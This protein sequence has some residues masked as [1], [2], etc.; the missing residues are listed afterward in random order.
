MKKLKRFSKIFINENKESDMFKSYSVQKNAEPQKPYANVRLVIDPPEG[1]KA[2]NLK[3]KE[4]TLFVEVTH[5]NKNGELNK[6]WIPLHLA[7]D[8]KILPDEKTHYGRKNETSDETDNTAL[9]DR[10]AITDFIFPRA[11]ADK[12]KTTPVILA[13]P[14]KTLG[15]DLMLSIP[16]GTQKCQLTITPNGNVTINH[17]PSDLT[18]NIET[19][20]D[21]KTGANLQC[22][23]LDLNAKNIINTHS[24]TTSK[25]KLSAAKKIIN[26]GKL[27]GKKSLKA[28]GQNLDNTETGQMLGNEIDIIGNT[29]LK[30]HGLVEAE[31]KLAIHTNT[32]LTNN[33]TGVLK[34][35]KIL[36]IHVK[37]LI[38]AGLSTA[39]QSLELLCETIILNSGKMDSAGSL[40]CKANKIIQDLKSSRI[41]SEQRLSLEAVTEILNAGL[42]SGNETD[43]KVTD[44]LHGIIKQLSDA[45]ISAE[46][47]LNLD[48]RT[49]QNEGL[50]QSVMGT[51]Q[52]KASEAFKNDQTGIVKA[53]KLLETT[54]NK[55]INSGLMECA[56]ILKCNANTFLQ[57]HKNSKMISGRKFRLSVKDTLKNHGLLFGKNRF[58]ITPTC[59]NNTK[60]GVLA[61]DEHLSLSLGAG[62]KNHGNLFGKNIHCVAE[63]FENNVTGFIK[64]NERLDLNI[65]RFRNLGRIESIKE[66][67]IKTKTLFENFAS[68]NILSHSDMMLFCEAIIQNSGVIESLG[69]IT[70]EAERILQDLKSSRLVSEQKL[71]LIATSLI[72]NLGAMLGGSIEATISSYHQ[73]DYTFLQMGEV[74]TKSG[75]FIFKGQG[76][77]H[78]E[79]S[80]KTNHHIDIT[81]I[82]INLLAEMKAAK[83]IDLHYGGGVWVVTDAVQAAG[84]LGFY[85]PEGGLITEERTVPGSLRYKLSPSATQP[86]TFLANQKAEN[87][88]LKIK[89]P[90]PVSIGNDNLFV[91][92]S[93]TEK[94][95]TKGSHFTLSHGRLLGGELQVSSDS[96]LLLGRAQYYCG[97]ISAGKMTLNATNNMVWDHL[98]VTC[99]G[100]FSAKSALFDDISSRTFIGENAFLDIPLSRHYLRTEHKP[101][102]YKI[103]WRDWDGAFDSYKVIGPSEQALTGPATLTVTKK[104]TLTGQT[105]LYGSQMSCSEFA[106]NGPVPTHFFPFISHRNAYLCGHKKHRKAHWGYTPSENGWVRAYGTPTLANFSVGNTLQTTQAIVNVQGNVTATA[107]LIDGIQS[108]M[109]GHRFDSILRLPP[110]KPFRSYIPL[111]E[112]LKPTRLFEIRDNGFACI[113]Q[114]VIPL[115]LSGPL[116]PIVVVGADGVLRPNIDNTPCLL[117]PLQ[118]ANLVVDALHE[119]IQRG[120][121]APGLTEPQQVLAVLRENAERCIQTHQKTLVCKDGT[122]PFPMIVYQEIDFTFASGNTKKVLVPDFCIP[123][124]LDNPRL[125]DG[126]AGLFTIGGDMILKGASQTNADLKVSGHLD[127][128]GKIVF[129]QFK[130]VTQAARTLTET[131][132]LRETHQTKSCGGLIEK[133][134]QSERIVQITKREPGNTLSATAVEYRDITDVEW[135]GAQMAIGAGGIQ[136]HNVDAIREK[137]LLTQTI[138]RIQDTQRNLLGAT[139]IT[140]DVV[141]TQIHP[142]IIASTGPVRL[143]SQH[144]YYDTLQVFSPTP[145]QITAVKSFTLHKFLHD[146]DSAQNQL[147]AEIAENQRTAK[148]KQKQMVV[149]VVVST[150]IGYGAMSCITSTS[151]FINLGLKGMHLVVAK[152]AIVGGISAGLMGR[153]PVLGALEGGAFAGVAHGVGNLF[154][155]SF[156]FINNDVFREAILQ[157]IPGVAVGGLQTV[158]HG[159]NVVENMVVGGVANLV[160]NMVVPA[161]EEGVALS[162]WAQ[163]GQAILRVAMTSG[164]TLILTGSES[165]ALNM[166]A[167]IA[168]TVAQGL[169][170]EFGVRMANV[171]NTPT[172]LNA[173]RNISNRSALV[174]RNTSPKP[175]KSMKIQTIQKRKPHQSS[176]AVADSKEILNVNLGE[177]ILVATGRSLDKAWQGIQQAGL[178][179]G[180]KFGWITPEQVQQYTKNINQETVLYQATP[181][182]QSRAGKIT[183][184][185]ADMGLMM[186]IPG[187]SGLR[188]AKLVAASFGTGAALGAIEPTIDGQLLTRLQNATTSGALTAT[189]V[190]F[191]G[192]ACTVAAPLK[193]EMLNLYNATKVRTKE[194]IEIRNFRSPLT[195]QFTPGRF[196][197]GIPVDI[198][199]L[200][201]PWTKKDFL[202]EKA[203]LHPVPLFKHEEKIIEQWTGERLRLLEQWKVQDIASV[204]EKMYDLLNKCRTQLRDRMTPND[205]AGIIKENRGVYVPKIEGGTFNHLENE[206][207]EVENSFKNAFKGP[208]AGSL[209]EARILNERFGEL[210]RLWD[211]FG[212]LVER[213]KCNP[214]INKLTN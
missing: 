58:K 14:N 165:F 59:L 167:A 184:V 54:T 81:A 132:I 181:V 103:A 93:A 109:I 42:I 67:I 176:P 71:S 188:G 110:P 31:T 7:H 101:N 108:G 30:N 212:K 129:S 107:I 141:Q 126:V 115:N 85:W 75:D 9:F 112:F 202:S 124:T 122:L 62:S 23:A 6:Q 203:R 43:L 68:G 104:L 15:K 127:S 48:S 76:I 179:T 51:C 131:K 18:L 90:T 26:S 61:S 19:F 191:I 69:P 44:L 199:K 53:P 38:N 150:A 111:M 17:T 198:I 63:D 146:T 160:G 185:V 197:S 180:E 168:G 33:K 57:D 100:D 4:P 1:L 211:R 123:N 135:Q 5:G 162:M 89:A 41:A 177:K 153:N 13:G 92:L 45:T 32:P 46:K 82:N 161:P 64:A 16:I 99:I 207:L 208:W 25:L 171:I 78:T 210:S 87:G 128:N 158:L 209:E 39:K 182:K 175:S 173:P 189:G 133:T 204:N 196:Y 166:C 34:S 169:G 136:T 106:G 10:T 102:G 29:I 151:A 206:L 164:T 170:Q 119:A 156:A 21:I 152:G 27:T 163:H 55:F 60:T 193:N 47:Q 138:E 159:G 147:K 36:D 186:A 11:Q 116:G 24:L 174:L 79:G 49:I 80:I 201:R 28:C 134:Q 117:H 98:E 200:Q 118:E 113:Y 22:R 73:P 149:K 120:F 95:K 83:N 8:L 183:E 154:K 72:H 194:F 70:C 178:E 155:G 139:Y 88:S 140:A 172:V 145:P 97:L 142:T 20:G 114:P 40:T 77:S 213:A 96:H 143:M 187:G 94:L 148:R 214:E 130:K 52:V 2:L 56:E 105:T 84:E 205:L 91:T 74:I 3:L 37:K 137:V 86:L 157:T 195:F 121:L 35:Q 144:G 190:Y 65:Q 12:T 66:L 125:R 192:K 50:M